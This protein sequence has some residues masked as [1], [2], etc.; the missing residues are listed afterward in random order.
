MKDFDPLPYKHGILYNKVVPPN[1]YSVGVSKLVIESIEEF[2]KKFYGY[3]F[4]KNI[5]KI[6]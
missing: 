6:K 1:K 2:F 4:N 5:K 3:F